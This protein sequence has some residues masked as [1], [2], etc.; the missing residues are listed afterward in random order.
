M[1]KTLTLAV[2]LALPSQVKAESFTADFADKPGMNIG[3]MGIEAGTTFAIS[4]GMKALFDT[5]PEG[6][7]MDF[8]PAIVIP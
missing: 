1:F 2:L 7:S 3:T 4:W 5:T 8:I 6:R